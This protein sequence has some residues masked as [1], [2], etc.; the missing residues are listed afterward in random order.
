VIGV[1]EKVF[2]KHSLHGGKAA[3]VL[4]KLVINE[5]NNATSLMHLSGILFSNQNNTQFM[6][7]EDHIR[8]LEVILVKGK[9]FRKQ[10]FRISQETSLV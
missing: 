8:G 2:R 10:S 3:S 4:L 7:P 9:C 1:N 5:M 6:I